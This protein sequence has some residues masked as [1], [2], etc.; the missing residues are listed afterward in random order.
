VIEQI[1]E[2]RTENRLDGVSLRELIEEGK[3]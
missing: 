3:R 1:K 2:F